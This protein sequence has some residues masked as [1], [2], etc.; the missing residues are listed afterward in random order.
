MTF[1]LT[2]KTHYGLN[3]YYPDCEAS[4]TI[5]QWMKRKTFNDL[6]IQKLIDL[7]WK[8]NVKEI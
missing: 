2:K 3:Y 6:E 8:V 4:K 7:G 5:L 1:Q